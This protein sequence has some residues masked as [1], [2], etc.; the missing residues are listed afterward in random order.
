MNDEVP[1]TAE[2]A[3]DVMPSD[4]ESIASPGQALV[5]RVLTLGVDGAGP[6]HGARRVAEEHL[7]QHGDREKAI[8]KLIATHARTVGATGFASGLGGVM[9]LPV[10]IPADVGVF[11]TLAGRCAAA[12]A[13]LRGYDLESD[14]VRSVILVSLLGAGGATVL[15]DVGV[16]VGNKAAVSALKQLPGRVLIDINKKVGFRLVTKF[17]STGVINLVRFV[18]L[19]GGGVAAGVNMTAMRSVG[20][21][22]KT[23]FPPRLVP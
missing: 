22:A 14:E 23:H 5:Q 11:Y 16:Q 20:R 15:K 13:H 8:D 10:T 7:A 9:T 17:G 4:V 6:L 21:Y 3:P 2:A 12:V 19:A 1:S 18:P